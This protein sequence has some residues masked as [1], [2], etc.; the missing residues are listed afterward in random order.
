MEKL[1][2][3]QILLLITIVILII[4]V[5]FIY[6]SKDENIEP[7]ILNVNSGG[8]VLGTSTTT[9]TIDLNF[10]MSGTLSILNVTVGDDVKVDQ[11]LA[12]LNATDLILNLNQQKSNL[13][14]AQTDL[15]KLKAGPT[16]EEIAALQLAI[17]QAE[18]DLVIAQ[19]N[20]NSAASTTSKIIDDQQSAVL[21]VVKEV[22]A[23]AN[24]SLQE[25]FDTLN[26]KGS[27]S[28]FLTT[29]TELL[30]QVEAGYNLALTKIDEAEL[31][32]NLAKFNLDGDF[33]DNQIDQSVTLTL[34]ALPEVAK[35]LTDLIELLNFVTLTSVLN[36]TD[37]VI[38]NTTINAEQLG[39]D[40]S[41]T[42]L[43]TSQ[44]DLAEIRA[45][46][47][48]KLTAASDQ[49]SVSEKKFIESESEL[50]L[51]LAPVSQEDIVLLQAKV[52]KIRADL[53]RAQTRYNQ[54]ILRSP[55][56]GEIRAI[57]FNIGEQINSEQ[58]VIIISTDYS[59]N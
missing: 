47:E 46:Q 26:Y 31:A 17:N 12:Q 2:K 57:N 55:I 8:T 15:D 23:A 7:E 40:L 34:I 30:K 29:N 54:S 13:A 10:A 16:D 19:K 59:K 45:T 51:K 39:T 36:Q 50:E 4:T 56:A 42:D 28:N 25:I 43:Q 52:S 27:S 33:T 1:S 49:V 3:S 41:I 20:L 58:P 18:A 48:I 21:V 24:I 32:Y 6:L 14:E 5:Y 44:N 35:T 38:L 11:I 22:L 37:L 53:A 9:A